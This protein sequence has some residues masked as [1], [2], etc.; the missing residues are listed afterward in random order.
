MN[1]ETDADYNEIV[2]FKNNFDIIEGGVGKD[3]DPSSVVNDF[4]HQGQLNVMVR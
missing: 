2:I 1:V 4:S 3:F